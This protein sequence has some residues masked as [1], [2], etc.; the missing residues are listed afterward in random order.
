MN[1]GFKYGPAN[2]FLTRAWVALPSSPDTSVLLQPLTHAEISNTQELHYINTQNKELVNVQTPR[3]ILVSQIIESRGA[4]NFPSTKA[5]VDQL[6]SSDVSYLYKKLMEISTVSREKLDEV[7]A[8]LDIQ[9]NPVFQEDS[10]DCRICQEKK[11]DY[12]RGCGFLDEDKRDKN[13]A[14]PRIGGKRIT[15]CPIS[16][17]DSYVISQASHAHGLF[18]AGILP[19]DGGIGQQ[20]EWFV[21]IALLY[22]RKIAGAERNSLE[23]SKNK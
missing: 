13:P 18:T 14:L 12:T 11:L 10:W 21:H 23:A 20:T 7:A 3:S 17:L 5:I 15:I 9:F 1:N 2:L 4:I 8:M 16:T 19:E 6:P 22:K